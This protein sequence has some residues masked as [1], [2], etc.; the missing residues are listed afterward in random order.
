MLLLTAAAA[1]F[2][3]SVAAAGL[4]NRIC[5]GKEKTNRESQTL[6]CVTELGLI[7]MMQ[8]LLVLVEGSELYMH[9]E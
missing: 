4:L 8:M 2:R 5:S 7:L 1:R 6:P 9:T 3:C